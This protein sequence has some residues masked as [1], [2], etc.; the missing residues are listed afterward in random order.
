VFPERFI[1]RRT[2]ESRAVTGRVQEA[3]LL[4]SRL[5]LLAFDDVEERQVLL[6][7]LLGRPVPETVTIYP[8]FHCDYGLNLEFGEGVFVNQGCWFLDIGGITIGDR[9]MIGPNVTLSTAGH[10]VALADRYS[11]ITCRPIAIGADVWIGAGATIMPGVRI[12]PGSVIGAGTVV[13][14]DV[15]PHTVVT[16]TSIVERRRIDCVHGGGVPLDSG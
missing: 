1:P 11:G 9:T 16:G 5:N 15:A 4:T 12:G 7:R 6:G 14:R 2:P 3:M 8:P 13:A 10:P